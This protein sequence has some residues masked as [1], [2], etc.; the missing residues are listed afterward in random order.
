MGRQNKETSYP[1][2]TLVGNLCDIVIKKMDSKCFIL[3]TRD[4][5]QVLPV[6]VMLFLI[7]KCMLCRSL[8]S[9]GARTIPIIPVMPLVAFS[10]LGAS[11][12]LVKLVSAHVFLI[13]V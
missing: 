7:A 2:S 12:K 13:N 4:Y 5:T 11:W 9:V 3:S 8:M 1:T 6:T 10:A